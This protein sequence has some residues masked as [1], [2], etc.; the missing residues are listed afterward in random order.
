MTNTYQLLHDYS[1]FNWSFTNG[2]LILIDFLNQINIYQ[3]L[4]ATYQYLVNAYIVKA[5]FNRSWLIFN[6]YSYRLVILGQT[7]LEQRMVLKFTIHWRVL[8]LLAQT[9]ELQDTQDSK[10]ASSVNGS[11]SFNKTN[12]YGK[13]YIYIYIYIY[14]Y[15]NHVP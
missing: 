1:L 12:V 15:V 6:G 8:K 3:Y 4:T 11:W 7:L 14:I 2:K 13:L 10:I 5:T 9:R